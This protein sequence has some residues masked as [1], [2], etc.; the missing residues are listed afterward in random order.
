MKRHAHHRPKQLVVIDSVRQGY[1]EETQRRLT[2]PQNDEEAQYR[3]AA[4][5]NAVFQCWKCR[6]TS[7][8]PCTP[9]TRGNLHNRVA[10]HGRQA[11]QA[12]ERSRGTAI[13]TEAA[14][15][16]SAPDFPIL[17]MNVG[18]LSG[19]VCSRR[20]LCSGTGKHAVQDQRHA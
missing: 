8:L 9:A 5:T 18:V 2:L 14:W 12:W 10:G 4:S 16:D 11:W 3:K 15:K 7:P 13:Q 19:A 6:E 20:E 17:C 1:D